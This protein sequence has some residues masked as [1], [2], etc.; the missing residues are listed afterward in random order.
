MFETCFFCDFPRFSRTGSPEIVKGFAERL[1]SGHSVTV[2]D[3]L[4]RLIQ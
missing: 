2:L 1:D 3:Q 4:G